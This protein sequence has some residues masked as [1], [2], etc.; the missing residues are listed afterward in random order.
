MKKGYIILGPANSG[1]TLL[2]KT[3]LSS[4]VIACPQKVKWVSGRTKENIDRILRNINPEG[5]FDFLVIDDINNASKLEEFINGF[6]HK[7]QV[8][9]QGATPIIVNPIPILITDL[10]IND[11]I[12]NVNAFR[13]YCDYDIIL[14]NN[15]SAYGIIELI[16]SLQTH[17]HN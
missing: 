1:K 14:T 12:T 3:I 6:R 2:A 9:R 13:I 10:D 4:Y 17:L 11:F 15:D 7:R 16:K 8:E 5:P